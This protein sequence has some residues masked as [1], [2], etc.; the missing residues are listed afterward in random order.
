VIAKVLIVRKRIGAYLFE[1]ENDT[2]G[3]I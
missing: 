1:L 3:T 2:Y